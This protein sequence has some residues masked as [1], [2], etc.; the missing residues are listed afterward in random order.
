MVGN[1]FSPSWK[2]SP[3]LRLVVDNTNYPLLDTFEK[4]AP[5]K[6]AGFSIWRRLTWANATSFS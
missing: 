1:K 6:S 3:P 4:T 5:P 2:P